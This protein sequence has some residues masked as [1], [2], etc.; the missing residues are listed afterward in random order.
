MK[1]SVRQDAFD[2]EVVRIGT[3]RASRALN[4]LVTRGVRSGADLESSVELDRDEAAFVL[5]VTWHFRADVYQVVEHV[6]L[7][8]SEGEFER[9]SR[10]IC[11]RINTAVEAARAKSRL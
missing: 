4:G 9:A 11:D 5:S 10:R 8:A 1:T 2:A 6:P 7:A 3:G